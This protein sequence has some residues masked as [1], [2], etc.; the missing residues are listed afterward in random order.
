MY[1][2]LKYMTSSAYLMSGLL[3]FALFLFLA[4]PD[5][6]NLSNMN[7]LRIVGGATLIIIALA[8]IYFEKDGLVASA[9]FINGA[10]YIMA[11]KVSLTSTSDPLMFM[12][13]VGFVILAIMFLVC[14]YRS[15]LIA[16]AWLFSAL[17]LLSRYFLDADT[18]TT[19]GGICCLIAAVL[20]LY[21]S[22]S[23]IS[24]KVKLPI[25]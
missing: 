10:M 12:F 22:I 15:I 18:G 14:E 2:D 20:F 6:T 24:A 16:A 5:F 19:V 9:M 25:L 17:N 3:M 21:V 13:I 8:V 23:L 1:S 7:V 4:V 11:G